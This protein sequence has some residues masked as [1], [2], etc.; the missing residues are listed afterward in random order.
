V[1]LTRF[2]SLE[3]RIY[4]A[5]RREE[6]DSDATLARRRAALGSFGRWLV[7]RGY[8]GGNPAKLLPRG[9]GPFRPLPGVLSVEEA[10]FQELV[11]AL[12]REQGRG[13]I[14]EPGWGMRL[15][16]TGVRQAR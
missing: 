4:L 12:R 16:R 9:R 2:V 3:L 15:R 1:T 13:V 7:R 11:L 10:S 14:A 8:I 5:Q 6:G